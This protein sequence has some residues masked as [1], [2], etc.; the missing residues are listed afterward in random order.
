V[1]NP[2]KARL[3]M[4]LWVEALLKAIPGHTRAEAEPASNKG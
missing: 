3:G 4:Q 1:Y 2:T